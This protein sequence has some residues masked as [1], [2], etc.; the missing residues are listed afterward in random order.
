MHKLRER[1]PKRRTSPRE[2]SRYNEYKKNLREDFNARCGYCDDED[3]W[4]G[5]RFFHVD[6]FVPQKHLKTISDKE[7]SNLVYSCP[8]CNTHKGSDWPTKDE[9]L[10]NNGREGYVDVCLPQY[11][12][13]FYRTPGGEIFSRTDLGEYMYR[14]LKLFLRRHAVIWKLCK[15]NVQIEEIKKIL[16]EEKDPDLKEK[17]YNLLDKYWEYTHQLEEYNEE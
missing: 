7:Y 8:Y 3:I 10:H 16:E 2:V 4:T 15:I 9:H 12:A 11:D 13:Q 6:H 14:K 17:H 1:T 5:K